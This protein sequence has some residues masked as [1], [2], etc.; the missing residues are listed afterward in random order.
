MAREYN[1]ELLKEGESRIWLKAKP[2]DE[3][4]ARAFREVNVILDRKTFRT[5]AVRIHNAD[6]SDETVHVFLDWKSG[7][8]DSL[9]IDPLKPDLARHRHRD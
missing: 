3:K 1:W 6:G 7:P 9:G 2:Q 4:Q 8:R 5:Q